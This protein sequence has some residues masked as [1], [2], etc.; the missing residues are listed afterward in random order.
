M[1]CAGR[2]L[3][4]PG[5]AYFYKTIL[6]FDVSNEPKAPPLPGPQSTSQRV[7]LNPSYQLVRHAAERMSVSVKS[8]PL[9]S[10]GSSKSLARA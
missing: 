7:N 4:I 5:R 3:Q 10:N 8:L 1:R 2:D 6:V 9:N